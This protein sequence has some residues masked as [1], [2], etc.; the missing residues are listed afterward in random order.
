MAADDPTLKLY[1]IGI[2]DFDHNL[3]EIVLPGQSHGHARKAAQILLAL[4]GPQA[5]KP[6]EWDA[7]TELDLRPLYKVAAPSL[8]PALFA[9]YDVLA[10]ARSALRSETDLYALIEFQIE[11]ARRIVQPSPALLRSYRVQRALTRLPSQVVNARELKHSPANAFQAASSLPRATVSAAKAFSN[12]IAQDASE[13][14]ALKAKVREEYIQTRKNI[15]GLAKLR[16]T[17]IRHQV[18][19]SFQPL[20]KELRAGAPKPLEPALAHTPLRLDAVAQRV[21]RRTTI[22]AHQFALRT[23]LN[24]ALE[25]KRVALKRADD[26]HAQF[27]RTD[28]ALSASVVPDLQRQWRALASGR[29]RQI[30]G[31]DTPHA[32]RKPDSDFLGRLGARAVELR[33]QSPAPEQSNLPEPD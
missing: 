2:E 30:Y 10:H 8:L 3:Y 28:R 23:R 22:K 13:I 31:P 20:F 18:N 32:T 29:M 25:E 9:A 6:F 4:T 24:P 12:R 11:Q 26:L 27:N 1:S 14:A 33:Q 19:K 21:V 7:P 17:D 15:S 5:F 16:I